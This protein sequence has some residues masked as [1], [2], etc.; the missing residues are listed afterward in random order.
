MLLKTKDQIFAACKHRGQV[1][2]SIEDLGL[3]LCQGLRSVGIGS[4]S[5]LLVRNLREVLD[6]VGRAVGLTTSFAPKYFTD[7]G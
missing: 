1:A 6:P 2:G 5:G 4:G 7:A 3:R